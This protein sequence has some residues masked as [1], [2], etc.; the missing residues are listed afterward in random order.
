[1]FW[2][3]IVCTIWAFWILSPTFLE[4]R[5]IF[6]IPVLVVS[7]NLRSLGFFC[8]IL[9]LLFVTYLFSSYSFHPF[10]L[11]LN[12]YTWT[13]QVS[14]IFKWC[15]N[16]LRNSSHLLNYKHKPAMCKMKC[17]IDRII[18]YFNNYQRKQYVGIYYV[19][20]LVFDLFVGIILKCLLHYLRQNNICLS[21]SPFINNNVITSKWTRLVQCFLKK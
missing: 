7:Y 5:S 3:R 10:L 12:T 16:Y 14:I 17:N 6:C 1:M 15:F 21:E 9:A 13:C 20:G 2:K 18:F 4:S 8:S 19:H 11:T